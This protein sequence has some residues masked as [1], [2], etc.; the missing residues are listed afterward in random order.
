MSIQDFLEQ[1]PE[2]NC[3]YDA[4][5]KAAN[6]GSIYKKTYRITDCVASTD[7]AVDE[8]SGEIGEIPEKDNPESSFPLTKEE[9]VTTNSWNYFISRI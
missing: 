1:F 8:K 4:M 3:K 5:K 2:K 7:K 9:D 6:I